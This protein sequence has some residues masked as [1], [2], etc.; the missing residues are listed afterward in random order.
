MGKLAEQLEL[1]D[2]MAIRRRDAI[3]Q[4]LTDHTDR[5]YTA[6]EMSEMM[7]NGAFGD[8][9]PTLFHLFVADVVTRRQRDDYG[10]P[11]EYTGGTNLKV[12]LKHKGQRFPHYFERR[13]HTAPSTPDTRKVVT[14]DKVVNADKTGRTIGVT[15]RLAGDL[16]F[17]PI[18]E[19]LQMYKDLQLFFNARGDA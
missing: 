18:N 3:V 8:L 6:K 16:H 17:I 14:A 15:V 2:S 7:G 1:L 11:L 5:F 12:A 19:A 13:D 4:F 9:T 10:K